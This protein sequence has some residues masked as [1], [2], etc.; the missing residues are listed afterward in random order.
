MNL[1][2]HVS[3]SV[4]VSYGIYINS[5]LFYETSVMLKTG[6]FYLEDR[7][8]PKNRKTFSNRIVPFPCNQCVT[9]YERQSHVILVLTGQVLRIVVNWVRT[10]L[11]HK[12]KRSISQIFSV[13]Y[14][15]YLGWLLCIQVAIKWLGLK[16]NF[17]SNNCCCK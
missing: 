1:S 16:L 7:L 13:I 3:L 17:I 14:V 2:G 12:S 10:I 8:L 9:Q 5:E 6:P 4:F 15:L 11:N